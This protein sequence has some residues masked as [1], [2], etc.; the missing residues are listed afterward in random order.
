VTSKHCRV[1]VL[2]SGRGTNFK[3][4]AQSCRAEDYPAEVACLI[5]DKPECGAV[6]I[7]GEFDIPC[8]SIDAGKRR[9]RLQDGAEEEIVRLCRE[10]G[11]DLIILA[12][13]MR[14]LRG[15]LLDA[16]ERRIINIHPSLLPSF[17]GLHAQR[18]ALDYGVKIAGCTVHFVDRS[19]DG[20]AIILQ[21][22]VDVHDD[23]DEDTLSA[24]ILAEE[25]RILSRAVELFALGILRQD[26]RNVLGTQ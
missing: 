2:A 8:H 6:S 12:G 13:F 11:V 9:G 7:A 10:E 25:H 3:A 20:G 23:D 17:P 21:A 16:F 4:I 24:R 14:I 1:A 22:S 15:A 19:V 26:G 18:Q 5:T